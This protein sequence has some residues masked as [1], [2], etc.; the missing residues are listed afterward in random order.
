[1]V[2]IKEIRYFT[3]T[4]TV[5]DIYAASATK[6]QNFLDKLGLRVV[7][8]RLPVNGE[9]ILATNSV[10]ILT[11]MGVA[12]SPRLILEKKPAM[13]EFLF[14]ETDDYREAHCFGRIHQGKLLVLDYPS[15]PLFEL[16]SQQ[17]AAGWI[18][19]KRVERGD[20]VVTTS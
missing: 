12:V 8:F 16:L 5:E 6:I 1:M 7:A 11:F 20:D 13:R 15:T 19:L 2:D 9:T 3:A 18:C 14:V 17:K 4:L 10:E